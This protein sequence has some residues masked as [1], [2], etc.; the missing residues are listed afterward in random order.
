MRATIDTLSDKEKETLRLMLRGY[1]AKSMAQALGLS[2]HT[3]NERLRNARRK[4]E[5]SSSR[6][7]ARRLFAHEEASYEKFGDTQLGDAEDDLDAAPDTP[8]ATRRL[9][10]RRLAILIIGGCV[11]SLLLAALLLPASPISIQSAAMPE[12]STHNAAS[13]AQAAESWLE[14]VDAGRW[15]DSYKGTGN[16]FQALNTLE[17][18]TQAARSVHEPLGPM[19]T[20]DLIANEFVPAPPDGYQMIKFRSS[21]ANKAQQMETITLVWA[22]EAWKVVGITVD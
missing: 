21:Y 22:D 17:R 1:D 7:A 11:M 18:W 19:L 4:L 8:T 15:E 2:V 12:A 14:L 13:A 10:G 20:R 6:E 16:Q 5:V 3:V 9:L